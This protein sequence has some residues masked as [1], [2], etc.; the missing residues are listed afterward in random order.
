MWRIDRD[1]L[2]RT[3]R[4]EVDHGSTYEAADGHEVTEHYAGWVEVDRRSFAQRAHSEVT[5]KLGW[6]EGEMCTY[7]TMDLHAGPEAYDV[8]IRL[9]AR[10]RP[11]LEE[12]SQLV[13]ERHWR[14]RFP[15]DLA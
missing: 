2:R 6:P 14:R 4:C 1:V 12:R 11:P 13:A 7:A 10:E 8:D 9:E 15:R 5:F 3:V